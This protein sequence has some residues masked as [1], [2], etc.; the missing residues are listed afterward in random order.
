M[1]KK[2]ITLISGLLCAGIINAQTD[3]EVLTFGDRFEKQASTEVVSTP[4]LPKSERVNARA[5]KIELGNYNLNEQMERCL[6][7]AID[8]WESTLQNPEEI[9]IDFIVTGDMDNPD[10]DIEVDVYYKTLKSENKCIPTSLYYNYYDDREPLSIDPDALVRIN[11]NITW[12][13]SFDENSSSQYPNFNYA[14]LRA[15]GRALGFGSSLRNWTYRG[16]E[17]VAFSFAN[18]TPFD[19]I[20]FSPTLGRLSDIDNIGKRYNAELEKFA[21]SYSIYACKENREYLMYSS[22]QFRPYKSLV[23]MNCPGSIMH[24][25]ATTRHRQFQVD[26]ATLD[27]LRQIGWKVLTEKKAEIYAEGIDESGIMPAYKTNTFKINNLT[28]FNI[29][30]PKWKLTMQTPDGSE[31]L[32][33]EGSGVEFI[34]GPIE[35]EK[36]FKINSNGDIYGTIELTCNINGETVRDTYRASF[37]LIPQIL[38]WRVTNREWYSKDDFDQPYYLSFE[39]EHL[40]CDQVIVDIYC[41]QMP[42][43]NNWAKSKSPLKSDFRILVPNSFECSLFILGQNAYRSNEVLWILE[44]GSFVEDSTGVDSITED[45][46]IATTYYTVD[47]RIVDIDREKMKGVYIEQSKHIDGSITTKKIL[48]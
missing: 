8:I 42:Y 35:N 5:G 26:N 27:I 2:I 3:V 48:L 23:F 36:D 16:S 22:Y 1:N 47:G 45:D 10:N 37:Q 9:K 40:G 6:E 44:K 43:Y 31:K 25:D 38:S 32:V 13:F 29:S 12:D 15:I 28:S 14:M 19:Y 17:I 46:V 4:L 20:I 30:N 33:K 41:T 24:Y 11:E 18:L 7:R 21:T 34:V 39:V